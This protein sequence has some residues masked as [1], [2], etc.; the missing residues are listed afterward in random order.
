MIKK[1][2]T[3]AVIFACSFVFAQNAEIRIM[4]KDKKITTK[5]VALTKNADGS[6]RFKFSRND[7]PK[8]ARDMFNIKSGDTL[9]ILCD[10]KKGMAIV[11]SEVVESTID[12]AMPDFD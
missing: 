8:D 9:V 4:G 12:K 1:V 7:I 3:L 11:K 5:Q 6:L 2:L 10:K